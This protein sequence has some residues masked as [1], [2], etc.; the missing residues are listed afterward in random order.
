VL[1]GLAR[2]SPTIA[3]ALN[4]NVI[5]WPFDAESTLTRES[6]RLCHLPNVLCSPPAM[7]IILFTADANTQLGVVIGPNNS[8]L[9]MRSNLTVQQ[10]MPAI[11]KEEPG[12]LGKN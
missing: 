8:A 9:F 3:R 12:D 10:S 11:N 6:N 4:F 7:N 5:I 2:C 1:N